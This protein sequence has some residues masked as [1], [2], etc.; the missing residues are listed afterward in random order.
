MSG[1]YFLI[2]IQLLLV[3]IG[4]AQEVSD[5]IVS[6]KSLFVVPYASYQPETSLATGITL[7]Y[8]FKSKDISKISSIS[9]SAVYT[10]RNQFIFNITPKIFF[11]SSKWYLYSNLNVK[12]YPDNYFG[13]SNKTTDTKQKFTSQNVSMMLQPQ[14]LVSKHLFL[15]PLFSARFERLLTDS[16]FQTTK[17]VIFQQFGSAGWNPYSQLSVGVVLAYDSRDNQFY[18]QNGIFAKSLFTVSQ[19]GWGSDYSL[20]EFSLDLRQYIPL[21]DSQVF[22]WQLYCDGVFGSNGIP[23][24]LL[25]TV[26]GRDLLRGFRQGKYKENVLFVAQA[27]YR[28]PVYKRLKAAV[29]CSAGDV[30]NSTD[31][32]IDKLKVAYGVGLRYRL[33]DARVHLR[34]D[35]AWN[36]YGDKLQAYITASEAF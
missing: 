15:G 30:T 35:I 6:R 1:R 20:Q 29:F 23:F 12:N 31:Y 2:A 18:P 9:G 7:G 26:G 24:E 3:A 16:E 10:F 11:Y 21:F 22:A 32:F 36:N 34:L 33:N 27:E 19:A 13:V 5:S 4:Y 14:Y 17:N 25:P 8:Y 28:L